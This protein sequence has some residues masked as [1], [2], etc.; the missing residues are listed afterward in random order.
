[1]KK[2]STIKQF[3]FIGWTYSGTATE[4]YFI[5]YI[6]IL[7]DADIPNLYTIRIGTKTLGTGYQEPLYKTMPN[8]FLKQYCLM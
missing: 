1:M 2:Y 8:D 6:D 3:W 5:R 7:P 4:N